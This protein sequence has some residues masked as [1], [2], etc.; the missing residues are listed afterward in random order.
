MHVVLDK[1]KL[2]LRRLA[3]LQCRTRQPTRDIAKYYVCNNDAN[4]SIQGPI[5]GHNARQ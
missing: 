2:H 3:A 4:F 5:V 1:F